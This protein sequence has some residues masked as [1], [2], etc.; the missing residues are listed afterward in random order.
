MVDYSTIQTILA[1]QVV[2]SI[3]QMLEQMMHQENPMLCLLTSHMKLMT[4]TTFGLRGTFSRVDGTSR[5]APAVG[6]YSMKAG[7]FDI[8]APTYTFADGSTWGP[9]AAW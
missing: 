4:H 5:F 3:I 1:I 6:S 9:D 7:Q 2:V 8:I